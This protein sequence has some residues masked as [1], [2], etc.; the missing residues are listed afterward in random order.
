MINCKRLRSCLCHCF[1]TF[2]ICGIDDDGDDGDGD[3]DDDDG[4]DGDDDDDIY[5][6]EVSVCLFVTKKEHFLLGVACNHL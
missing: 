4:D 5:Y 1:C 6:D 2:Q 3:D